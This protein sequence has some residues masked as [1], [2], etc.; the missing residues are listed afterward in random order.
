MINGVSSAPFDDA[1]LY[2]DA[3]SQGPHTAELDT[4]ELVWLT[5]CCICVSDCSGGRYIF[6]IYAQN[7]GCGRSACGDE[8]GR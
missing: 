6:K 2:R 4:C 1:Y 8:D 3:P 5:Q 7:S